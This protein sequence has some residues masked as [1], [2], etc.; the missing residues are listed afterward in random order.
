VGLALWWPK[1]V[2]LVL[3]M[4]GQTM[5]DQ[6]FEAGGEMMGGNWKGG[7]EWMQGLVLGTS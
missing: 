2:C 7:Q 4:G 6:A 5:M 1:I 3:E